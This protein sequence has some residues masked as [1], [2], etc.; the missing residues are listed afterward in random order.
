MLEFKNY[1]KNQNETAERE[2]KKEPDSAVKN[3]TEAVLLGEEEHSEGEGAI[4]DM[5][6][7]DDI[8]Y[9]DDDDKEEDAGGEEIE[10]EQ[11]DLLGKMLAWLAGAWLRIVAII[12]SV[13]VL[14]VVLPGFFGRTSK[15]DTDISGFVAQLAS[16][17]KEMI[18][19][20]KENRALR[21][22][23]KIVTD[24]KEKAK[25]VLAE[26]GLRLKNSEQKVV[27]LREKE[28]ASRKEN[29]EAEEKI[30]GLESEINS[31]RATSSDLELSLKEARQS[32]ESLEKNGRGGVVSENQ[33]TVSIGYG[34]D[35]KAKA[36]M[37]KRA[38]KHRKSAELYSEL[39]VYRD[40]F[41]T[42]S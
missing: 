12:A 25:A 5:V 9:P 24:E 22:E 21:E 41:K 28:S 17:G 2:I 3:G 1:G 4:G 8:A 37:L 30:A 34:N 14:G 36:D 31:L 38:A 40:Y 16:M 32:L 20:R 6:H 10:P 23:M 19:L 27:L 11:I 29:A 26:E 35:E 33:P 42:R 13:A 15:S 39:E 18:E 7:F